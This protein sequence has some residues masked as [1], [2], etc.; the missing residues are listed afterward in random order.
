MGSLLACPA[1]EIRE[2]VWKM[3][4]S[5][6]LAASSSKARLSGI[7]LFLTVSAVYLLCMI[8][9]FRVFSPQ[10][11][12]TI[13][14]PPGDNLQDFWNTWYSQKMLDSNPREFF[15]TRLVRYP[16]GVSLY[17]QSFAYSDLL[18]VLAVRKLF[19][20]PA[21]VHTLA[22]LHNAALLSSFYLA[23]LGAFYLARRFTRHT[24]SALLAGFI[25]GFSPFHVAHLL[26][27]MHVATIEFIPFFLLFFFRAMDTGRPADLAGSVLFYFLS[28]ISCW[29]Y[30][31]YI[32]YFL[33]FYYLYQAV[34]LKRLF[35]RKPLWAILGIFAGVLLL[36]SPLLRPMISQAWTNPDVYAPGYSEYGADLLGYFA[37]DPYH[38]L[39]SA[40]RVIYSHFTG[41]VTEMTVYLGVLNIGLFVWAFWNRRRLEIREIQFFAC[42]ILVFMIIASGS[43]LHFYGRRILAMP[44]LL[45]EFLPIVKNLRGA[46]RAV[47]FVYVFLGLGVGLAVD[48]IIQAYRPSRRALAVSLA[49]ISALVF[50]DFYPVGLSRTLLKSPAAYAVLAR[51]P[52]T[53]FGILDLPRGYLQGSLYMMFQTFHERPIVVATL[54]RRLAR[55]LSDTLETRDM[56][57]QKKQLTESKVKYIFIHQGWIATTDPIEDV[58]ITAYGTTYPAVYFDD[59]CVVLRVY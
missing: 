54:S 4:T 6:S 18:A 50:L 57:A 32:A 7:R 59:S 26:E 15:H 47:V 42:G 41:N 2:K 44:M 33:L 3:G 1:A 53:Q 19:A 11:T 37:F 34:T 12:T 22:A 27:H 46:S 30:L 49:V 55:T 38:L 56:Q 29:Y 16:E 48:A 13:I 25:F 52:D 43:F 10:F 8:P 14:G 28:A 9:L 20:L 58:D 36:L 51:D 17:Y 5:Q 45:F 24:I 40:G 35:L 21:D 39:A 23:A 31:F